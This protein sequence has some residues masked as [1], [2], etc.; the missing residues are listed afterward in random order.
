M[1]HAFVVGGRT[2]E[3]ERDLTVGGI[4]TVP[5]GVFEGVDYVALGH[6]HG[7]QR[8]S[9]RAPQLIRYSGSPLAFSFSEIGQTKSTAVVTLDGGE[10][11]AELIPAPVPRPLAQVEGR[12]AELESSRFDPVA[13]HWL[14]VTV[15][16]P[17]RP[18]DLTAR[19]RRRFPNALVTRH[20]PE[21]LVRAA[22]TGFVTAASDPAAVV[23]EFIAY[24]GGA[25]PDE[26]ELAEVTDALESVGRA[27]G[28]S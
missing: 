10:P 4:A 5:S 6:L 25:P 26:A 1:A 20:L 18:A 27:G 9:A 2:S 11:T 14:A 28:A 21:G 7:P 24:A 8:I 13:D 23:A 19:L 3:S 15:T 17:S 12:L 22:A 16:D